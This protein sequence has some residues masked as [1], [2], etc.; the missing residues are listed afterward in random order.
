MT[1][2]QLVL[3]T[4]KQLPEPM[5][6]E[7]L[8]YAQFLVERKHLSVVQPAPAP[9]PLSLGDKLQAI[10]NKIVDSD[11]PLL[12]RDEIEHDVLE[13]RGGYQEWV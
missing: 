11:M 6:Q 7:V 5:Q 9:A 2:E 13:R 8:H 12:N 3:E 4:L 1:T 10:R